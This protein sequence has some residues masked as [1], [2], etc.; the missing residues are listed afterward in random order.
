MTV[1]HR[2]EL[3]TLPGYVQGK[4]APVRD[5]PTYKLSSNENPYPPL[6]SVVD[7]I[8]ELAQ[9]INRYPTMNAPVLV[10]ALATR[11]GVDTSQI[12][13]G[14]GSVEVVSQAIHAMAGPGDEVVYAWRSFE[15]YPVLVTGAGATSV[16]VPL[17]ADLRHDLPAM[18]AAV[19]DRTRLVIVCNPNNPTGTVTSREALETFLDAVPDDVVV[20]LDEAYREFDSDPDSPDG[21]TVVARRPNVVVSRTFSKA[22]G[23]AGMRIGYGVA[24]PEVADLLRKMAIPFAVSDLA[25]YAA[26]ASLAALDELTD[27]VRVLVAERARIQDELGAQGWTLPRSQGN[28][29]WLPA[30]DDTQ[31]TAAVLD[32]FGISGR[33][34]PEG[35]RVSLG[36]RQANDTFIE[37]CAAVIAEG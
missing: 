27:R 25:Q 10:E 36:D 1:R 8:A 34:F 26:V 17:T 37:A 24:S 18:A 20:V 2:R 23:L 19:T 21:I 16:P 14:A 31:R 22:Y 11:H 33:V 7:R 13:L 12:V 28:F 35:I 3:D 29:V 4:P 9:G 6:P 30:A 32:R 5:I 15:A